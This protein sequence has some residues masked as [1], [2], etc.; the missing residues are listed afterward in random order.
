MPVPKVCQASQESR[1]PWYEIVHSK[2][3]HIV[4]VQHKEQPYFADI[5]FTNLHFLHI[6]YEAKMEEGM[7]DSVLHYWVQKSS[8]KLSRP[9]PVTKL[10]TG[11][12]P[13]NDKRGTGKE[14]KFSGVKSGSFIHDCSLESSGKHC[15]ASLVFLS[16]GIRR[17]IAKGTRLWIEVTLPKVSILIV[18]SFSLS[19]P[20]SFLRF[21]YLLQ[22]FI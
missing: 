3:S 18:S 5:L 22:F 11:C 14:T 2:R 13:R 10:R 12:N 17:F 8:W 15:A 1:S 19:L 9:Q 16:N 6:S 7:R 21:I 4:L 20:H